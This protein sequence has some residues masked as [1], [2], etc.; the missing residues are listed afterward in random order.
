MYN[1]HADGTDRG[2]PRDAG[3]LYACRITV[4]LKAAPNFFGTAFFCFTD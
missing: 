1:P 4:A 3:E 2:I